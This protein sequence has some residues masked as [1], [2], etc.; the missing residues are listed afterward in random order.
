VAVVA[1][2]EPISISK[3]LT[4]RFSF[5]FVRCPTSGLKEQRAV[6]SLDD[7]KGLANKGL[8]H[9]VVQLAV[10]NVP[11]LALWQDI[12]VDLH[13]LS[14]R[15]GTGNVDDIHGHIAPNAL[16]GEAVL[17]EG[18]HFQRQA[19]GLPCELGQVVGGDSWSDVVLLDH[20]VHVGS[21]AHGCC[22]ERFNRF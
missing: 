5:R 10:T 13:H 22:M 14:K 15:V 6:M 19:D 2:E 7:V 1:E 12:H 9:V 11:E 17:A 16:G 3:L 21:A 8:V 20:T 4:P 18:Q